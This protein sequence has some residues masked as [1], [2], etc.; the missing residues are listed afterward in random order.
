MQVARDMLLFLIGCAVLFAISE[1]I[2]D[3]RRGK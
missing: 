3:W 1:T 2:S